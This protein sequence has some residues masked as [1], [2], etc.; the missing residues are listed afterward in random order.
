MP[1]V[2]IL[3]LNILHRVVQHSLNIL[4]CKL[5]SKCWDN[6]EKS[7]YF[8]IFKWKKEVWGERQCENG[9]KRDTLG[10]YWKIKRVSKNLGK[11]NNYA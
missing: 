1:L 8:L 11:F 5:C 3:R 6:S 7:T 9:T 10:K 4:V 2:Q